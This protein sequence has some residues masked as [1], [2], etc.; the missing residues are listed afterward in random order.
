MT[1]RSK[2]ILKEQLLVKSDDDM[3]GEIGSQAKTSKGNRRESN[4]SAKV[5]Q[6][7]RKGGVEERGVPDMTLIEDSEM[8]NLG[9]NGN[10]LHKIKSGDK[11]HKKG[12]I[13]SGIFLVIL[14]LLL[15]L[16]MFSP[17]PDLVISGY[18]LL[19]EKVNSLIEGFKGEGSEERM[20]K[21]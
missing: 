21:K 15:G 16:I 12:L 19:T 2:H 17:I 5:R 18:E 4:R 6:N 7:L 13:I 11:N 3:L 14:L 10:E 20:F 1:R 8:I 9:V